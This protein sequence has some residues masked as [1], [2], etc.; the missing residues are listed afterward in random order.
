MGY[1]MIKLTKI[2]GEEVLVNVNQ[3]QTV[4]VIPESKVV[5]VNREYILVQESPEEIVDLI[6]DF[7]AKI[8]GYHKTLL[9][10]KSE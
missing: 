3:I 9:I 2:N 10:E 1:F 5:F 6:I 8:Y 7:N 4:E